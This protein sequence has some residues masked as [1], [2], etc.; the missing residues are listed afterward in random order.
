MQFLIFSTECKSFRSII[1]WV[2]FSN[3][4][5]WIRTQH[6]NVR[7]MIHITNLQKK[8][9]LILALFANFK[10]K[11]GRNGPNNDKRI[12]WMC[13]RIPFYTYL[14]SGRFQF[15]R[16]SQN[17]CTSWLYPTLLYTCTLLPRQ[18]PCGAAGVPN[19]RLAVGQRALEQRY[20]LNQHIHFMFVFL[21]INE[22]C[23][24]NHKLFK[25]QLSLRIR[26]VSFL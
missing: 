8:Y 16:Q 26:L 7:C 4:L 12:L 13:N 20:C 1:F 10:A 24:H 19:R 18:P 23:Q 6:W 3:F 5:Q 14:R 9:L 2:N 15:V 11:I 21:L 17:H 25:K 22:G